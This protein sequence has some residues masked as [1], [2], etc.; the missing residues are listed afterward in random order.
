MIKK[1]PFQKLNTENNIEIKIFK[2]ATFKKKSTYI[3]S[4][5]SNKKTL[6]N[7]Y[8][9][10]LEEKFLNFDISSNLKPKYPKLYLKNKKDSVIINAGFNYR[11]NSTIKRN[12]VDF[13]YHFHV[14][15]YNLVN[16][17]T[18]AKTAIIVNNGK[19]MPLQIKAKGILYFNNM[20]IPW[21][22]SHD[23][24]NYKE[25]NINN[26]AIAF[27]I[28]NQCLMRSKNSKII[29]DSEYKF[30]KPCTGYKNI[31]IGLDK[32][33]KLY[34]KNISDKKVKLFDGIFI[35]RT[36]NKIARNLSI[37]NKITKWIISGY[38]LKNIK[39]AVT[40]GIKIPK[41]F[42]KL[43]ENIKK[44]RIIITRNISDKMPYYKLNDQ[45]ARS[46]IF[47]TRDNK[48]HFLLVDARPKIQGQNG[49]TMKDLSEYIYK[50]NKIA[51]AVNCDGGQSSKICFKTNNKLYVFGNLHYLNLKNKIPKWDGKKWSENNLVR[52]SKSQKIKMKFQI[53]NLSNIRQTTIKNTFLL[54][55]FL[56][57]RKE[58][59]KPFFCLQNQTKG[60]FLK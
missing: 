40:V 53:T 22:G 55:V 60:L 39:N 56:L 28:S 15:N 19:I 20:K 57:F 10:K 17:P 58:N 35:L 48:I 30:I 43:Y 4:K 1:I 5:P 11:I 14:I 41:S 38:S 31:V 16:I 26:F 21:V 36:P 9:V 52:N 29:L 3:K 42:K 46:C 27:G 7:I 33:K 13:S 44:E 12:P 25:K 8:E 45:K 37:G 18:H 54:K 47:K 49:M 34:I 59:V 24:R 50:N 2:G 23:Y 32:D 6:V 51:W